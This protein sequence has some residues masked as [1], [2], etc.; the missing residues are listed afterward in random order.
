MVPCR[1]LRRFTA[2]EALLLYEKQPLS[3]HDSTNSEYTNYQKSFEV[4]RCR[5]FTCAY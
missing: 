1:V 2:A 3:Y 4:G 5:E